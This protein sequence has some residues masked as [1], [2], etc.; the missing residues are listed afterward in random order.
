MP[1]Y[2]DHDTYEVEADSRGWLSHFKYIEPWQA[3]ETVFPFPATPGPEPEVPR[4]AEAG[5]VEYEKAVSA[6]ALW[7]VS[8]LTATC[9]ALG[10]RRVFGKYD[11]GGDE[12]FT[13]VLGIEMRDGR[14]IS[15][16][17]LRAEAADV[18]CDEVVE[19]AVAALMGI[20][21]AGEFRLFGAVT[22]DFD[23]C[24]ITDEKNRDVVNSAI[25]GKMPWEV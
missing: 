16:A 10:V 21:D 11:G 22:I 3:T 13:H 9:R 23:A 7:Q 14:M 6:H 25:D 18:P 5:F 8:E 15:K 24:T 4:S 2:I 19:N 17:F 12:G 20:F 1:F